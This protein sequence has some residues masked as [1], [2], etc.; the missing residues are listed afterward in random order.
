V[1]ILQLTYLSFHFYFTED[2]VL[3][4]TGIIIQGITIYSS[5]IGQ[6]SSRQKEIIV[7]TVLGGSSL[8]KPPLGKNYHLSMRDSNN[9]WLL[10]KIE[11]LQG[12]FRNN[13]LI[14]DGKTYRCSSICSEAFTE[15]YKTLYKDGKR[16]ITN[17]II[18]PMHDIGLAIWFIDGG[19]M[20]GRNK[21][22]AY[23]NSTKFG[24]DGSKMISDYFNSMEIGCNIN[25]SN[26]RIKVLFTVE[27]T[28][29]FLKIVTPAFPPF[30]IHDEEE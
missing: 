6:L 22:N 18:E 9:L 7:G 25:Q 16:H 19:G 27:G 13:N 17:E 14:K 15:L 28:E 23:L 21:K 29:R 1:T 8:V 26:E 3:R 5:M 2:V 12:C 4:E 11:E 24:M 20:T 30:M 10:Y